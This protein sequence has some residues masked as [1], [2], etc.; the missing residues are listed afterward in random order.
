[1]GWLALFA[2]EEMNT[3]ITVQTSPSKLGYSQHLH[4]FMRGELLD[5]PS[6]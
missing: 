3:K 6:T 4:M 5:M 1:M 2:A